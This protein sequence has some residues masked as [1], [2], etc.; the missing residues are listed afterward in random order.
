MTNPSQVENFSSHENTPNLEIQHGK[1]GY[2][3]RPIESE[4]FLIGAG[5]ICDLQLGSDDIPLL[6]T[7]II[8]EESQ[9][10]A[11][12]FVSYP[13][14]IV[15]GEIT[16][17]M[18]LQDGDMLEIGPFKFK[19]SIPPAWQEMQSQ[20]NRGKQVYSAK[21]LDPTLWKDQQDQ[22][23]QSLEH[24]SAEELVDLIETEIDMIDEHEEIKQ[25]GYESMLEEAFFQHE[26]SSIV[27]HETF[28]QAQSANS[29][30]LLNEDEKEKLVAEIERLNKLLDASG[31][32]DATQP[33]EEKAE[34]TNRKIA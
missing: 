21:P 8:Q 9:L 1:T 17:S 29:D 32:R 20:T 10:I 28:A 14:L 23:S 19:L 30:S 3:S 33:Q 16:R 25:A 5:S 31:L 4:R 18:P 7:A 11:E 22:F 26:R 6:H 24:L 27:P 15:N 2:P 13:K 34:N 12:S